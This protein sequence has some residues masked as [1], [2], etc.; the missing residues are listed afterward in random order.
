MTIARGITGPGNVYADGMV[1]MDDD[2]GEFLKL[3]GVADNHG[4][5]PRL[6]V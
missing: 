3:L 2:L 1:Q 5:V 6:N 4:D